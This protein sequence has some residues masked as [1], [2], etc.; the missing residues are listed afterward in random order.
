[1]HGGGSGSSIS[2]EDAQRQRQTPSIRSE[3]PRQT[4]Y[5]FR[6]IELQARESRQVP[7]YETLQA[8]QP[9]RRWTTQPSR[10]AP[11]GVNPIFNNNVSI[12][13]VDMTDTSNSS[14]GNSAGVTPQS[15]TTYQS[16]NTSYSPP[17]VEDEITANSQ[18]MRPNVLTPSSDGMFSSNVMNANSPNGILNQGEPYKL[19]ANWDIGAAAM[20]PGFSE[21]TPDGTWDQMMNAAGMVWDDQKTGMTPR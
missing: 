1:M 7:S 20:T 21:M 15:T 10:E 16:N 13:D 5:A 17:I 4:Q 6:N 8:S 2:A 9:G 11:V 14:F 19:P 18:Q 12:F 3:S